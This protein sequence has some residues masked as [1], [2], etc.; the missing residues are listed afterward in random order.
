[1]N[2][3]ILISTTTANEVMNNVL[4]QKTIEELKTDGVLLVNDKTDAVSMDVDKFIALAA[5][6]PQLKNLSISEKRAYVSALN[7][8][9]VNEYQLT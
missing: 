2:S 9:L 7:R 1:M 5:S 8:K 6:F 3:G 4:G